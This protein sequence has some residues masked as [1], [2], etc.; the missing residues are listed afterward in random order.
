MRPSSW[1]VPLLCNHHETHDGWCSS[2]CLSKSKIGNN[3]EKETLNQS[4]SFFSTKCLH[5]TNRTGHCAWPRCS[6]SLSDHVCD[7]P[8]FHR[9]CCSCSPC[10]CNKS[11]C[12]VDCLND[13]SRVVGHHDHIGCFEDSHASCND[14]AG[15]SNHGCAQWE[16][17]PS[18]LFW[19]LLVLD[20]L[21]K[22]ASHI[23]SSLTL[24]KKGDQPK[25]VRGH[26]LVCLCKLKL[27]CL[28]LHE[29]D[30]LALLIRR[31][32]PHRTTDVATTKFTEELYLM[33]HE[34]MH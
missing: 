20:D 25:R 33:P 2:C 12:G 32:Q 24:L 23:I 7:H 3:N 30:F 16:D 11:D 13:D 27:M 34:L 6:F 9:T 29:E 14:T 15:S 17:E 18:L 22:N 21:L 8:S 10:L 5:S 1:G 28:G 4:D 26:H 19:L 31:G